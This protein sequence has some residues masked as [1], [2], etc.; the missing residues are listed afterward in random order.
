MRAAVHLLWVVLTTSALVPIGCGG[1]TEVDKPDESGGSDAGHAFGGASVGA[2]PV[3]GSRAKGGAAP[4][5]GAATAGA[6][7]NAYGGRKNQGGTPSTGGQWAAGG[8]WGTGGYRATGG[9]YGAGGYGNGGAGNSAAVGGFETG[10]SLC[11]DPDGSA[12][13]PYG[14][15]QTRSVTQGVNGSFTDSC[16]ENGNLVE[17]MC[18]QTGCGFPQGSNTG[19]AIVLPCLP[20]QS[21]KVVPIA[22]DCGGRCDKGACLQWCPSYG[23]SITV[24]SVSG[25]QVVIKDAERAAVYTCTVAFA[26]DGYDCASPDLAKRK[27][28]VYSLG[29]CTATEV[30]FG[31]DDATNP[32]VQECTYDCAVTP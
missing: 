13:S 12:P 27:L 19:T 16:D 18:E 14:A 11:V 22:V 32:E 17:Y 5:G 26:V 21:G 25:G 9:T 8:S 29:T 4:T 20:A 1:A 6:A 30:V 2:G 31:V 28:S 24:G 7:G 3:G 15:Y 10:G 23:D